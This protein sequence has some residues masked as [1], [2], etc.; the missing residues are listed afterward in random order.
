MDETAVQRVIYE[1]LS[2]R[3]GIAPE[4]LT[5]TARFQEDLGLDSIEVTEVLFSVE[6][7][8]GIDLGLARLA[9]IDDVTSIGALAAAVSRASAAPPE[10]TD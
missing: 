2:G 7:Q 8:T 4:K 3:F 5:S 9:T 1:Y 10:T 6:D